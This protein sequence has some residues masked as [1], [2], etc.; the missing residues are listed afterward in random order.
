MRRLKD[1]L[2]PKWIM[3]PGKVLAPVDRIPGP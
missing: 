1:A 3:N 2:D